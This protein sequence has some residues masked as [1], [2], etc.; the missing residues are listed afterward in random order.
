MVEW[1]VIWVIWF[2]SVSLNVETCHMNL[3]CFILVSM[4]ASTFIYS[5]TATWSKKKWSL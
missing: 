1:I 5:K 3:Y 2:V 4:F